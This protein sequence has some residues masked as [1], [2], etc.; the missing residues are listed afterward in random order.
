MKVKVK[1]LSEEE[2]DTL[3]IAQADDDDAWEKPIFVNRKKVFSIVPPIKIDKD[4][5]NGTPV[6]EGTRVPAAA[7][8][9]NLEVSV[10]LDKFLENF[11]TV[12]REQ[13]V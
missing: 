7:L 12:K 4:V 10:S 13:A 5:L 11:L 3:I 6:F 8:L 1:N 2:I 9:D